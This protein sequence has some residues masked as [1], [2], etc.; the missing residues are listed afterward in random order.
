ME[1]DKKL[2]VPERPGV[3]WHEV[4]DGRFGY[5]IAGH[6]SIKTGIPKFYNFSANIDTAVYCTG[7]LTVQI[8]SEDGLGDLLFFDGPAKYAS[9]AD[10]YKSMALD[11]IR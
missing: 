2:M 6:D 3:K 5:I 9:A 1:G 7:R 10:F 11:E 4:Y 8:F